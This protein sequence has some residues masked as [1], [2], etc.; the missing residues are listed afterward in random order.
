MHLKALVFPSE[1]RTFP[2]KRWLKIGLRSLHIWSIAIVVGAYLYGVP[3]HVW[4]LWHQLFII[5]GFGLIFI[6]AWTNGIYFLQLRWYVVMVKMALLAF[7]H[8]WYPEPFWFLAAIIITSSV[9]AHAPGDVRYFSPWHG[10]RLDALPS[11]NPPTG[12]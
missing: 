4:Y 1:N 3:Q 2:G 7:L 10:R 9:V 8:P 11:K 12:S 5:T 6:E